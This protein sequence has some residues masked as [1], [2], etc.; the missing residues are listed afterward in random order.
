MTA[1][2]LPWEDALASAGDLTGDIAEHILSIHGNRGAK[3]IDAVSEGRVKAYNDF[4]VVVGYG[5]EY[6]VEGDAC[7]CEDAMYNLDMSDPT[8]RC[9]HVL[10]VRIAQL[11]DA[12]DVHDMWYSDVRDFL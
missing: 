1:E 6:V 10:A 5:D 11:T 7:L 3:A 2:P 9:W 12:L 8:Q 4:M